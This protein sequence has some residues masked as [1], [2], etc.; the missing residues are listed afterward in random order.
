MKQKYKRKIEKRERKKYG[1]K[2]V[3][4]NRNKRIQT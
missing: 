2:R 4:K 1:G 3:D